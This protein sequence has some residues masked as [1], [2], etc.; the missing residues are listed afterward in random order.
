M[1]G[2]LPAASC[3]RHARPGH[4]AALPWLGSA[5]SVPSASKPGV[6]TPLQ[7]R[8]SRQASAGGWR[9]PSRPALTGC[10]THTV[11]GQTAKQRLNFASSERA[12]ERRA[13]RRRRVERASVARRQRL[14]RASERASERS[15]PI[16]QVGCL[17]EN[18]DYRSH[19]G[20]MNSIRCLAVNP[21]QPAKELRISVWCAQWCPSRPAGVSGAPHLLRHPARAT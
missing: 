4:L 2:E 7:P 6:P 21:S 8:A 9:R 11:A 19:S 17:S 1:P 10:H 13:S 16:P 14:T 5:P 12:S 20:P 3:L 15:A 18:P